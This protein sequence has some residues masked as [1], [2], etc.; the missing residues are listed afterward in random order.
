MLRH[1]C[2]LPLLCALGAAP[3]AGHAQARPYDPLLRANANWQGSIHDFFTRTPYSYVVAGTTTVAGRPFTYFIVHRFNQQFLL[4]EDAAQRRVYILYPGDPQ[5]RL[6][7]DFTLQPGATFNLTYGSS[8]R[9]MPMRVLQRDS[10]WTALG[11][12]T[13]I[14]LS[15]S[16]LGSETWVE[17]VGSEH[18]LLYLADGVGTDP[19]PVL[20]C[21]GRGTQH[22]YT[23]QYAPATAPCPRPL[24]TRTALPAAVLQLQPQPDGSLQLALTDSNVLVAQTTVTD[25]VG[26]RLFTC[27]GLPASPLPAQRWGRGLYVVSLVS[28]RGD[29]LTRKFQQP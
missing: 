8:A 23:G 6:L 9:Q 14:V 7:Y 19:V 3:V 2:F 27:A 18:S 4:R 24:P 21:A 29:V 15:G 26:R 25:A 22:L 5:E 11:Y 1:F 13:R 16:N 17:G 12:R 28:K 20:Y 10:V